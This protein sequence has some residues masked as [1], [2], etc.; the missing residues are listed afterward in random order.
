MKTIEKIK[1]NS[2]LWLDFHTNI[3]NNK[4]NWWIFT[5]I[6]RE[7]IYIFIISYLF[8]NFEGRPKNENR[9]GRKE[10]TEEEIQKD[11]YKCQKQWKQKLRRER[12]IIHCIKIRW[13]NWDSKKRKETGSKGLVAYPSSLMKKFKH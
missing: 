9:Q 4:I 3:K 8:S 13:N 6:K 10:K 5:H 7:I 12:C 2:A 11:K 1:T